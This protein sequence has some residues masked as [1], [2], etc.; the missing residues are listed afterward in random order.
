[1]NNSKILIIP[2]SDYGVCVGGKWDVWLMW[3]HPDGMWVSKEKL[4]QT[5]PINPF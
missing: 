2:N 5:E 3:R 1:M 4:R